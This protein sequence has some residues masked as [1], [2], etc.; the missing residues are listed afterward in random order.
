MH[1]QFDSFEMTEAF[2][3]PLEKLFDAFTDPVIK[4]AW[5][6]DG[7]HSAT[8]DTTAY[9][10]DASVGGK[11]V[12]HLVLNDKTPVPGMKIE[13]ES[14]C[15]AR[16]DNELLVQRSTMA[17]SGLIRSVSTETFEFSTQGGKAVIRLTQQGTYLE[18]S[19]GPQLRR[20]GFTQVFTDLRRLMA[21]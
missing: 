15:L 13:M 9:T 21:A 3:C 7:T 16:I 12:Y 6:V 1:V 8:H 19:D 10:L 2:D 14:E 17:S 20:Q 4:R 18:G 5:Y 11:E